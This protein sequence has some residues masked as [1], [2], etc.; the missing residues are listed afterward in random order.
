MLPS[1]SPLSPSSNNFSTP[2]FVLLELFMPPYTQ[3]SY[4]REKIL[5]KELKQLLLSFETNTEDFY[6]F[7][8]NSQI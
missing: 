7:K 6:K 5:F 1:K 2:V 8:Q 4:L 3:A